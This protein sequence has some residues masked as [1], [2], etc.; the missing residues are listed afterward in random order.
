MHTKFDDLPGL[1]SFVTLCP[2][3]VYQ[4]KLLQLVAT[5]HNEQFTDLVAIAYTEGEI[6]GIM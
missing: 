1:R 3:I 5:A 2:N 4:L 6:S